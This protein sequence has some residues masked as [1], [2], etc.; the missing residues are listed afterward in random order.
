MKQDNGQGWTPREITAAVT[1]L[2]VIITAILM[3]AFAVLG[4]VPERQWLAWPIIVSQAISVVAVF[5]YLS[6]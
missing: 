6:L 1:R 5:V 3:V 2:S 4:D